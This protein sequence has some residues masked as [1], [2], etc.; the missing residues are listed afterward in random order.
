MMTFIGGDE[1]FYKE[2][3]AELA[4]LHVLDAQTFFHLSSIK[5]KKKHL[6]KLNA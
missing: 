3:L 1:M 5:K 4:K 6:S 2:Q